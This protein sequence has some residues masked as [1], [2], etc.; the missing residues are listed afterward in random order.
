MRLTP[1]LYLVGSGRMGFDLTDAHDCHVYLLDGGSEAAL[2]DGGSGLAVDAIMQNVEASG[3]APGKL[4]Y[5]ILTHGHADHAGGAA[6]LRERYGL[7]VIASKKTAAKLAKGG[8]ADQGLQ[9]ALKTGWYPKGFTLRPCTADWVVEEGFRIQVGAF[10]LQV[11]ETPGH[12]HDHVSYVMEHEGRVYFFGGDL[13]FHGGRIAL[14]TSPDCSLQDY[15]ASLRRL[16]E[17]RIDALLPGHHLI[18]LQRAQ[19]HVTKALSYM[20]R[21]SVPPDLA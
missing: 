9:D 14:L 17:V 8:E 1:F 10:S 16:R 18:T 2:I 6:E 21:L 20:E 5:L 19:R 12:C 15:L 13:L 7:Q 4:K 3:V 11:V